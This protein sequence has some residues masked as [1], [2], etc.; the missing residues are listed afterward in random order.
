MEKRGQIWI[1]TVLYTLIGM[2]LIGLVLAFATPVI[3][4]Q[5]DKSVV[6]ASIQAISSLDSEISSV[7]RGGESNTREVEIFIKKGKFIIGAANSLNG[8]DDMLIFEIEDS[9][10]A[11]SEVG[12]DELIDISGTN[13]KI[14]T[15]KQGEKYKITIYRI[16][17]LTDTDLTYA[18][19]ANEGNN[20]EQGQREYIFDQSSTPYR[21]L[22]ENWGDDGASN[23]D[24]INFYEV[25]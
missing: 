21:I 15:E 25:G 5:K 22:V 19:K 7:K 12:D 6:E 18:R 1:E 4:E 3:K 9:D 2:V 10:Y 16:Y 13:L 8:E 17:P 14:K 23:A 24:I 11:A 20:Q